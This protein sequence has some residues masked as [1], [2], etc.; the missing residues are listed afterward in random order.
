MRRKSIA[1]AAIFMVL[2][3]IISLPMGVIRSADDL[4]DDL[5]SLYYY[6]KTGI[7]IYDETENRKDQAR[8]LLTVTDN[9]ID[10]HSEL[11]ALTV[12]LEKALNSAENSYEESA[13]LSASMKLTEPFLALYNE[14]TE[15]SYISD[16]DRR[17]IGNM[18]IEMLS[19]RD[20][21][22]NSTY[23][24]EAKKLNERLDKFPLSLLDGFHDV[25]PAYYVER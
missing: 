16:E 24:E 2:M 10:S 19:S 17:T 13:Q 18:Q 3:I 25:Q 9:Y 22:A 8:N 23:N 6:D 15:N 12:P 7:S 14:L 5:E 1:P 20:I 11:T 4:K 21:I